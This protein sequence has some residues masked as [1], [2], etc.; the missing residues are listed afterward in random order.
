MKDALEASVDIRPCACVRYPAQRRAWASTACSPTTS[1]RAMWIQKFP[2]MRNV[3]VGGN[4]EQSLTQRHPGAQL[5]AA[6]PDAFAAQGLSKEGGERQRRD[7]KPAHACKGPHLNLWSPDLVLENV[8][9]NVSRRWLHAI[10]CRSREEGERL[11]EE[12]KKVGVEAVF[13]VL[14]DHPVAGAQHHL[15]F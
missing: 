9:E 8:S 15:R 4:G 6:T 1:C 14:D 13:A 11:P 10:R 3:R 2:T 5:Q 7:R 12:R